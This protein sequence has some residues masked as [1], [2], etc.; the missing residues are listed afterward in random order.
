MLRLSVAVIF[1]FL[2]YTLA[3][4]ADKP[5][6]QQLIDLANAHSPELQAAIAATFESK[7]LDSGAAWIGRG[8]DF[9]FAINAKSEPSLVIDDKPGSPMQQIAGQVASNLKGF[10]AEHAL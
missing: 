4:S 3:W 7:N 10:D 9:F 2:A 1:S 8:P 5:S 6:V